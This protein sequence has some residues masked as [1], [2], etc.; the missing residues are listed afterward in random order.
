MSNRLRWCLASGA[1]LS[2]VVSAAKVLVL[3][4]GSGAAGH[5]ARATAG[6]PVDG[7]VAVLD[8]HA[9]PDDIFNGQ[10]CGGA[11]IS[12]T[13]VITAAHCL[14]GANLSSIDV[15]VDNLCRGGPIVGLR[16]HVTGV[17]SHPQFSVVKYTH[18]IAALLLERPVQSSPVRLADE[19]PK[20]GVP[21]VAY[22]WGRGSLGGVPS[23][24]LRRVDLRTAADIGCRSQLRTPTREYDESSMLCAKVAQVATGD[25]CQ[26]DSGGPLFIAGRLVGLVSWGIGCDGAAPGAYTSIAGVRGWLDPW[27]ARR[28]A[29]P[30]P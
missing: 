24:R 10:F 5:L 27:V 11:L 25:T 14:E 30:S 22:G 4:G 21:A 7:V 20:P 29:T 3:R 23:C 28:T 8:S 9:P 6:H 1:V 12:N 13:V 16:R 19:R 17:V 15:V 18:D 2:L 26:G